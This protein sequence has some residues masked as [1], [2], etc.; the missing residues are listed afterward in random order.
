[1]K[2][3]YLLCY[4]VCTIESALVITEESH[5]IAD[6]PWKHEVRHCKIFK[7]DHGFGCL[8]RHIW[9]CQSCTSF[10]GSRTILCPGVLGWDAQ[11]DANQATCGKGSQTSLNKAGSCL[12]QQTGKHSKTFMSLRLTS[13]VPELRTASRERKASSLSCYRDYDK[14]SDDEHHYFEELFLTPEIAA[15]T[16]SDFSFRTSCHSRAS[17]S[18]LNSCVPT[19]PLCLLISTQ[20]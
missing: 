1:M 16:D 3:C 10:T 6:Y 2:T 5:L 18:T 15:A 7:V 20:Q 13:P 17:S 14:S 4:Y 19:S 9:P 12:Q 11:T 8:N